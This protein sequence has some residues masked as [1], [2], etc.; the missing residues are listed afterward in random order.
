MDS[1]IRAV[2]KHGQLQLLDPVD[3]QDGKTVEITILREQ[4]QPASAGRMTA[5]QLLKATPAIR[6]AYLRQAAERA[7]KDY[8]NNPDLRGFD[9]FG[10]RDFFL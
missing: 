8:E 1:S 4:D 9:A 2:F 3:L 7:R 5:Q 6:S 10:D